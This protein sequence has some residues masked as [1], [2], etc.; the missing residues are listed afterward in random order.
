[1]NQIMVEVETCADA[2]IEMTRGETPATRHLYRN[3]GREA[4]FV[5][6]DPFDTNSSTLISA[7]IC[8]SML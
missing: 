7:S 2:A 3:W 8:S 5:Y 6:I 4:E 1:M